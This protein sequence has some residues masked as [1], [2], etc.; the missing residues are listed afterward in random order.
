[1]YLKMCRVT[2]HPYI[3]IFSIFKYVIVTVLR[4]F[5]YAIFIEH[6]QSEQ[7]EVIKG[8]LMGHASSNHLPIQI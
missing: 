3:E 7:M 1:M 6:L 2:E 4:S 8:K 5:I